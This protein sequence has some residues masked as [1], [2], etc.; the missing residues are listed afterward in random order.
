MKKYAILHTEA[1]TGWGG[2]EM[3]IL[4]EA[5]GMKQ[6]GHSVSIACQPGAMIAEHADDFGIGVFVMRMNGPFDISSM[7][8]LSS[9]LRAQKFDIINTHSSKDSWCAGIAAKIC[10][11]IKTI[12]TRHL[13]IPIRNTYDTRFL[14]RTIPDAVVTTGEIIR[15]HIIDQVG[16]SPDKVVSIPTGIDIERFDPDRTTGR[17]V[18][19]EFAIPENSFLAG[20]I[21]MMRGMKGHIYFLRAAIKI[22]DKYPNA[23][24]LIV[25]DAISEEDRR[26]K[27]EL[28]EEMDRSG[29][30]KRVILTGYRSD[31]AEILAALDV[32][33]LAS[34]KHEGL[35]QVITQAMAMKR[36]V[37]ATNVGGIPE[38]VIEGKTGYMVEPRNPDQLAD[39]M[40][41]LLSDRD[42]ARRIGENGRRHVQEKFTIDVMLD[43]TERLY[44]RLLGD[45]TL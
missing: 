20:T 37:V 13:S 36:P 25:G 45:R 28:I 10:L 15:T 21:G 32:F 39:A 16:I 2:Q 38:Q 43:A 33:V 11:D 22:A 17:K 23:R 12:R 27:E 8:R 26:G 31:I 4:T 42:G 3:R 34:T 41:R 35:P 9:L 24:F 6:R 44:E 19:A 18:R 14:Y 7:H 29:L 1:S 5:A 40:V 30:G